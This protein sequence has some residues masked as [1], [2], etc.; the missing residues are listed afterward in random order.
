MNEKK[1]IIIKNMVK[2]L[3]EYPHKEWENFPYSLIEEV[4]N[5]SSFQD[6]FFIFKKEFRYLVE[7]NIITKETLN[8]IGLETCNRF[9]FFLNEDKDHGYIIADDSDVTV[10]GTATVA[11]VGLSCIKASENSTVIAFNNAFV[12]CKDNVNVT[13]SHHLYEYSNNNCFVIAKDNCVIN[14]TGNTRVSIKGNCKVFL[15]GNAKVLK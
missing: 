12:E 7:G 15:S 9:K 4:E 8:Y 11:A 2:T 1:I 6:I 10:S 3:I 13:T 5:I 14:A